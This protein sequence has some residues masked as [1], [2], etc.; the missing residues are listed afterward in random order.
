MSNRNVA[1]PTTPTGPA[2][3]PVVTPPPPPART[4]PAVQAAS[5]AQRALYGAASSTNVNPTGGTGVDPNSIYS[6]SVKAL[7]QVGR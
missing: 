7:G 6:A 2:A 3:A 1:R 4:D 5:A